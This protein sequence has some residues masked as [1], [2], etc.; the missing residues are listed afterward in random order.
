MELPLVTGEVAGQRGALKLMEA[1][2]GVFKRCH[3]CLRS[4]EPLGE[5]QLALGVYDYAEV[6]LDYLFDLTGLDEAL[7]RRPCL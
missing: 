2:D 7:E 3:R 4:N 6:R 5:V 1:S